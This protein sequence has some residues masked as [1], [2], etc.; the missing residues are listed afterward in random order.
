MAA[1]KFF[2][3]GFSLLNPLVDAIAGHARI[4]SV[5]VQQNLTELQM[6]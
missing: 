2:F 1:E 6:N 4:L 3:G 5:G